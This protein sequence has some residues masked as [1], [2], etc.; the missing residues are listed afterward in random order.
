MEIQPTS[1]LPIFILVAAGN[2]IIGIVKWK[3]GTNKLDCQL[4]TELSSPWRLKAFAL[5]VA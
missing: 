5:S 4:T 1:T 3:S 2:H